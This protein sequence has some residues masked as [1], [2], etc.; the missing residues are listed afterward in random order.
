MPFL[1][2]FS[3]P[4]DMSLFLPPF[5]AFLQT[6]HIT[7]RKRHQEVQQGEMR[8][9]KEDLGVAISRG[10]VF[11]EKKHIMVCTSHIVNYFLVL[12]EDETAVF[13]LI[14]IDFSKM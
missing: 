11:R 13:E 12:N 9:A 6:K 4:V 1:A 14:K 7:Q 3:L 10:T 2:E 8:T 5:D